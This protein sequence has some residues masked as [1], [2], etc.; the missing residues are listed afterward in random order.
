[1]LLFHH[2][3][4][5]LLHRNYIKGELKLLFQFPEHYI[6]PA[7][8]KF[9]SLQRAQLMRV[10][11]L[12]FSSTWDSQSRKRASHYTTLKNRHLIKPP[13]HPTPLKDLLVGLPIIS[14]YPFTSPAYRCTTKVTVKTIRPSSNLRYNTSTIYCATHSKI[15]RKK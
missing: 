4:T 6:R 12:E 2:I 3:N 8:N 7:L 10:V 15:P 5:R 14:Q 11:C 1:M 9:L 13:S